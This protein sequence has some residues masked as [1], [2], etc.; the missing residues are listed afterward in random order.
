M[1]FVLARDHTHYLHS[2]GLKK[3][4]VRFMIKDGW[5]FEIGEVNGTDYWN[6]GIISNES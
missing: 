6:N 2:V 5:D 4:S 1:P 3:K